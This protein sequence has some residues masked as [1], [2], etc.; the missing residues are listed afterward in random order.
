MMRIAEGG[1]SGGS[2]SKPSSNVPPLVSGSGRDVK[3]GA[4]VEMDTD[5]GAY[6]DTTSNTAKSNKDFRKFFS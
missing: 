3:A 5:A 2:R 4:D 1:G 6:T